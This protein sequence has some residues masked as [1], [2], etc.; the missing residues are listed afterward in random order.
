M[1]RLWSG[2][3]SGVVGADGLL[4]RAA[5]ARIAF[6]D[7]RVEELNAIVHP[8]T[9]ARQAELIA[10]IGE[11]DTDAVVMVESALIFETKHAGEGGRGGMARRFD[12]MIF[13][14]APEGLRIARFVERM[15]RGEMSERGAA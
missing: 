11:K 7:G 3:G 13:V 4:D 1:R 9:I 8:A 12:K 2:L 6:G 5:L 15:S 14:R 10:E